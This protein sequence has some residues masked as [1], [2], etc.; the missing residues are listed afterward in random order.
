MGLLQHYHSHSVDTPDESIESLI[1][2]N[3]GL[4]EECDNGETILES[5][6][7]NM[8]S[9]LWGTW[10]DKSD[11]TALITF[12]PDGRLS[13]T[14]IEGTELLG[15]GTYEKISPEYF[16]FRYDFPFPFNYVTKISIIGAD[17]ISLIEL[18]GEESILTRHE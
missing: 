3:R 5:S 15:G 2:Q 9:E 17:R 7:G 4:V 12:Y 18:S 10:I 14:D 1:D 6:R 8:P 13:V 11:D 16:L